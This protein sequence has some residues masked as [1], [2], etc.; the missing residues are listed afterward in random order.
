MFTEG[1]LPKVWKIK[2]LTEI[3]DVRD[4]TH[5]SPKY[6]NEGYPLVTSKNV[7]TGFIDFSDVNL[8]SK[9][10][11]DNINKRS[12]VDDGDILMPMIGTIGNPIIVKKD[13]KFAI[14]NVALIKFTKTDVSNKYVKLFLESIH[15]KHY[16]KKINRG[17][18]QKFISLKDIRNFPV[19]LPPIEKQNKLIKILEKAEKIKEW[20]VEADKLTDE[21]LKSVFLE[22]YNSAS[23]HPDLKADYLS[24]SLRDVKNGLSRR[25]KISEN[26]GDIV[27]RLKDIRENK[28][29]LTE[30]NRI[31]L[32]ELEKEKYGV[33]R[34]DLLFIRVNGN[35]DYV[36]RCAVF[37]EFNENIYFNDH[38]MRVKIDSNQFNPI[39]L[40]F[41]I[42]SEYGKKQLKNHLRTSAGQYTINQKG[43]ERLKFYQPDIS[44]QNSFVDLFNKIEILKK[45]QFNSEIKIKELFD[46]LMQKAFK[47]ELVC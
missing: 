4:G 16:I 3:C 15:F 40:A 19:I 27:L 13:R 8:I 12:Y 29:D 2:K 14:K 31:P 18:T 11:Y 33:E 28:I 35:K 43:L 42:N 20:R 44:L 5:D 21:Y 23:H 41:L 6:K 9:D 39:F 17:G 36:G 30:L 22:I 32:N 24:E 34:N 26:K 38:I 45:D 47:G 7:A 46:T 25:R 37:R 1:D 10:D